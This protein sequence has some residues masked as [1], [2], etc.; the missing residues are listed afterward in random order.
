MERRWITRILPAIIAIGALAWVMAAELGHLSPPSAYLPAGGLRAL[1]PSFVAD[2]SL[3]AWAALTVSAL[4]LVMAFSALRGVRAMRA[5]TTRFALAME[6]ALSDLARARHAESQTLAEINRSVSQEL[7]RLGG[8]VDAHRSQTTAPAE[9]SPAAVSPVEATGALPTDQPPVASD[10]E[11][12]LR[13]ALAQGA[14]ELSL[15]AIVSLTQGAAAAFEAH[16]HVDGPDAQS[17]DVRRIAEPEPDMDRALF[18]RRFLQAAM[19]VG[20]QRLGG[21]SESMPLHV[22]IS[23][24]LLASDEE[25][26][27]VRDEFE[28]YPALTRCVVLSLPWQ[29]AFDDRFRSRIERL[30]GLDVRFAVEGWEGELRRARE[31]PRRGVGFVKL[32][33]GL[34]LDRVQTPA[35]FPGV[36]DLA[37]ALAA[38]RIALIATEVLN[39]DDAINLV[40]VGVDLMCGPRFSGPRRLRPAAEAGM[41]RAAAE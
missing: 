41:T 25:F 1:V 35:R 33:A 2:G 32:D 24:E 20:R 8:L 37:E 4:A 34:L 3:A 18:E 5:E 23:G 36:R 11:A 31:L 38:Q 14:L 30:A 40:E 6:R 13:R 17:Y 29:V 9:P 10:A 19:T 39:D 15:Q 16:V 7:D 21:S 28:A 26:A 22:A 12:A 27:R